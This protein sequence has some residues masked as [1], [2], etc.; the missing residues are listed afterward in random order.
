MIDHRN[1][2]DAADRA[3][4]SARFFCD[5]FALDVGER[6]VPERNAGIAALL[7]AVVNE[8]LLANIQIPRPGSA[9]PVVRSSPG[10]V[11]LKPIKPAVAVFAVGFDFAINPFFASV[12]RLYRALAIVNDSQ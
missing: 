11:F 1:L 6:V 3:M 2:L 12:Q 10:E 7:R 5:V 9:V 8:A 4:G